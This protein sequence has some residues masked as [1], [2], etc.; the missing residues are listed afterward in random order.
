MVLVILRDYVS[1][2]QSL[3][4]CVGAEGVRYLTSGLAVMFRMN[5]TLR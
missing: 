3:F 2:A 1:L 4:V 5:G